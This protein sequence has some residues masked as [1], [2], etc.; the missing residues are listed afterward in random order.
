MMI[1]GCKISTHSAETVLQGL[2]SCLSCLGLQV[3]N[4]ALI[5]TLLDYTH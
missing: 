3:F 5:K 2:E 4:R 1:A